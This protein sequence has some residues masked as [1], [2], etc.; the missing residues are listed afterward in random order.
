MQLLQRI[1]IL[2]CL[3]SFSSCSLSDAELKE[4]WWKHCG[5]Y[6]IGDVLD[7]QN[8][9]KLRND[10][11]YFNNIPKATIISTTESIFRATDRKIMIKSLESNEV[12]TY[13]QK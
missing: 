8:V 12:G 11:I 3:V 13:C 9:H 6:H 2:I 1:Y 7:F 4:S 10:T 5:D